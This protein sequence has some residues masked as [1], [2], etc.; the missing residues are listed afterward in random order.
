MKPYC[1]LIALSCILLSCGANSAKYDASG[2]FEATEV[3]VSARTPGELITF[4][5]LEGDKVEQ[6]EVLG[7]IDT[8][9]LYLKKEQLLASIRALNSRYYDVSRQVAATK[10]QLETQRKE[11]LRFTQLVQL[12]AANQKQLD[13]IE[14][15]IALLERE[16]AAQTETL[17]NNNSSLSS[18]C[19]GLM[20]QVAQL[21]DQLKKSLIVTPIAGT[22]LTKY[23]EQG[24]MATQGHALCKVADITTIYLRAYITATQLN[25]IQLGEGV[26][27]YADQGE[28]GRKS[29]EGVITWVSDKAEFTPK[30][31]QTRDER[32]NLVYAIKVA[33][34]NDGYIKRGMYGEI[35]LPDSS[36]K[37]K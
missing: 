35:T 13:D 22:I 20:L 36:K 14:A 37:R 1:Y 7:C 12:N 34:K 24:E 29:Y 8:T 25:S 15:S 6:G 4:S 2:V 21:E 9:Q 26:T 28:A 32:A 23:A 31:I 33:V 18:E 27:L 10:Q 3:I 17:T 16:L 30:T 19:E 5:I 11:Q